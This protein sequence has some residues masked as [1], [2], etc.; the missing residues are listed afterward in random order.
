MDVLDDTEIAFDA[1]EGI[2]GEDPLSL[3]AE[4]LK[5]AESKEINDANA[6][7]LATCDKTGLPNVRMV[8]LKG[9]DAGGFSFYTNAESQKGGEL[10]G[11]MQAAVV[12]HWK[13]LRRQVRLRGRIV[14]VTDNEADAYFDTRP[15][16]SR[17]G[18]WASQQSRPLES[19]LAL[20]RAVVQESAR[21]AIGPIPRPPHWR[22]YRLQPTYMEFWM[23]KPFR[24]HDR[25]VFERD[26]PGSSWGSRKLFP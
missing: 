3:F 1:G 11:N 19:R 5:L 6:M 21:F 10:A 17:I 2:G 18:A 14:P 25:L 24:L 15:R 12:L 16:A 20:Q 9:F 13:S 23:D 26:T 22:G 8:L 4:W 7:A